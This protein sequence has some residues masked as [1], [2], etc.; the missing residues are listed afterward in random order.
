MGG[1]SHTVSGDIA[2]F[3]TPSRV[4]IE[5]LKFHFLPKQEGSGDPSPTN[6]CPITGWTG[7]NGRRAGKNLIDINSDLTL[8]GAEKVNN[9][10]VN[11]ITD[12]RDEVQIYFIGYKKVGNNFTSL[13]NFRIVGGI[14]SARH[15]V[16]NFTVSST[17]EEMTHFC[18]KHNG[19]AHDFRVYFPLKLPVGATLCCSLDVLS[20]DVTTIGGFSM[21]NMQ[22]EVGSVEGAYEPYSGEQIPITFPSNGKNRYYYDEDDIEVGVVLESGLIRTI[23]H[24]HVYGNGGKIS[25]SGSPIDPE[26]VSNTSINIGYLN[27]DGT[28]HV[29]NSFIAY[30]DGAVTNRS[31]VVPNGLEFVIVATG[32]SDYIFRRNLPRYNIQIEYADSPTTYEPYSSDNTFYGGY[33]DPINGEIWKT[34][35]IAEINKVR[36]YVSDNQYFWYVTVGELNTIPNIKSENAGLFA[37]RLKVVSG[38][39]TGNPENQITFYANGIIR[40][41]ENGEMSLSEYET[42]LENNPITICYEMATPILVSTFSPQDLQAFLDHNNFWSDANDITEVTYTVTESKDILATRKKAMEFDIGHRRKVKW[43]QWAKPLN[44]DNYK[45]YNANYVSVAFNDGVATSTWLTDQY[46]GYNT[47]IRD[48]DGTNQVEGEIWYVS[49]IMKSSKGGLDWGVEF[50]GGLQL[51]CVTNVPADEWIMCQGVGVC[52]RTAP[53]NFI[54]ISNLKSVKSSEIG[55]TTQSKAPILINLTQMFGLGNEPETV[56]EFER[57]CELNGIDLTTYQPY[58]EGSDRWLIVP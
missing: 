4:P 56:E 51:T 3:R 12:T 40:W 21:G 50:N 42:Y 28:V 35:Y 17:Y 58:D 49:Y 8:T 41:K 39:G 25:I 11:T 55:M 33:I 5:S 26:V 9:T 31:P 54:Y 20:V 38:L 48:K 15:I 7:L 2:S 45:P 52:R 29:S 22:L 46:I 6:V 36:Q 47:S 19:K 27:K 53:N 44:A 34:H 1:L 16:V 10:F 30:Q 18:I 37:D 32:D 24:T 43:N 13:G 23:Y 57:I 14:T